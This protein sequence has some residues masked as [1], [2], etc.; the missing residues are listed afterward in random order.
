MPT[1]EVE[2][3]VDELEILSR[4][5]PL[6]F[7]LDEENVDETLR[8]RYRWLDLRRQ[9]ACSATSVRGAVV[10]S[11]IVRAREEAGVPRHM[12][13][14]LHARTPEG[15]RDFL[16]PVRLQPGTFFAL[17]AVA[18]ALQAGADD[19]RAST[20]TTRSRR[21]WRDEDLRADRLSSSSASSTSSSPSRHARRFSR[22]SSGS[23]VAICFE[24]IGREPPETTLPT[25]VVRTTRAALRIRQARPPLRARDPGRDRGDPRI[26]V[27]RLR[28][29]AR[30][31]LPGRAA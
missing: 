21:C 23:V 5:T 22:C 16:V 26:R 17:A 27:R 11:A 3:L 7:Q 25:D 30:R 24:A 8:L 19:R 28:R 15:A 18:A 6:P 10:V 13:A 1:G 9:S 12:D 20:A 2:L 14:D 31:P 4:S 29:C